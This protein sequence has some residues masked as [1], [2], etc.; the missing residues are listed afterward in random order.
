MDDF[1]GVVT[2]LGIYAALA[3]LAAIVA[4]IKGRSSFGWLIATLIFPPL[5]LVLFVLPSVRGNRPTPPGKAQMPSWTQPAARRSEPSETLDPAD[6]LQQALA[7][8]GTEIQ[9][10][11]GKRIV[12]ALANRAAQHAAKARREQ[13]R[14]Q[15]PQRE[16]RQTRQR[17]Q[18]R[19]TPEP[20]PTPA[21]VP[22]EPPRSQPIGVPLAKTWT[23]RTSAVRRSGSR[24]TVIYRRS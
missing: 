18:P 9:S 19:P 11:V 8:A 15:R 5:L 20:K 23:P 17:S 14:Q 24:E 13:Q 1:D 16:N 10:D 3:V 12:G 2:I 22:A 21:P 7:R 6:A 4:A